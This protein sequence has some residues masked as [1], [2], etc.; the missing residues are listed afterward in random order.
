ML[1][2]RKVI[3]EIRRDLN[4]FFGMVLRRQHN[5]RRLACFLHLLVLLYVT[6]AK[7]PYHAGPSYGSSSAWEGSASL[8]HSSS[9]SAWSG[10]GASGGNGGWGAFG[11][12][13]RGAST[14]GSMRYDYDKYQQ[15]Y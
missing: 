15:R 6:A 7:M 8:G 2:V 10:R 5:K 1:R 3:V 9:A 13:T 14:G 11:S 4:G 12:S